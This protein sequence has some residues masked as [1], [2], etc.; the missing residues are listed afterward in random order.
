[1]KEL[2]L[3]RHAKSSWND[4]QLRD[5]DRP[6]N[7]RGERDAPLMAQR[8]LSRGCVPT[9]LMCSPAR[10]ALRT[11]QL[12][13]A[14]L[15]HA[16]GDIEIIEEL[17]EADTGVWLRVIAGLAEEHPRVLIVGHNPTV[18]DVASRLCPAARLPE[19]PTCAVLQLSYPDRPWAKI[20]AETPQKWIF[21]YPKRP[22]AE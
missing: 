11:A 1:M 14:V 21:D 15:G 22:G 9:L 20:A 17:Y 19:L 12:M 6:L 16:P 10:R 5:F 18:S 13:A 2:Y 3:T 7:E 4:P 8:L